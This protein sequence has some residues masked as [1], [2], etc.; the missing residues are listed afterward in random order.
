MN[1]ATQ[2]LLEPIRFGSLALPN[3][4]VMASL[5]RTRIDNPGLVPTAL[6]A[7]YYAQRRRHRLYEPHRDT[8]YGGGA[9]GYVDYP[10]AG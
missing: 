8:F 6:M 1:Q 2:P 10:T 5:T 4:V 3:R 7:E 9:R